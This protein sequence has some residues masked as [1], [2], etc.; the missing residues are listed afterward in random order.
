MITAAV[1]ALVPGAL[2]LALSANRLT[3]EISGMSPHVG[4]LLEARLVD[5]VSGVEITRVRLPEISSASFALELDGLVQGREYAFELYADHNGNGRYDAPPADHAWRLLVTATDQPL[6]IAFEHDTEFAELDWNETGSMA[7]AIDG[8]ILDAEYPHMLEDP[9]TG[10][11]VYW[12]NDAQML[13]IA[14][15]SPGTG[16]ASIGLD[17]EVAMQGADYI[18]AAMTESGLMVEDHFGTGRFSHSLDDQQDILGAAGRESDDQTI[19]EFAILLDSGD[20]ADRPLLPGSTY[21]L[22]LAYHRSS[23]GFST[24]HSARGAGQIALDSAE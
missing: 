7:I 3:L 11:I 2:V 21:D 20:P 4:Q 15:V 8:E 14:L 24:R 17:P 5:A 18:L 22:L 16:W 12:R 6:T 19:V 9:A 23:D 10:M 1:L 13:A